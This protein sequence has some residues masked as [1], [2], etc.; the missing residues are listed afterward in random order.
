VLGV[1]DMARLLVVTLF[2]CGSLAAQNDVLE[3]FIRGREAALRQRELERAERQRQFENE[4]VRKQEERAQ[5]TFDLQLEQERLRLEQARRELE[6]AKGGFPAATQASPAEQEQADGAL[7][8]VMLKLAE[9]YSDFT[10]HVDAVA[11]LTTLFAPGTSPEWTLER[12]LE[13]LYLIAKSS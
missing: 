3:A 11:G 12:Y 8:Q 9:R 13:G 5:K 7:K 6:L 1:L 4:Q 2:L 10:D